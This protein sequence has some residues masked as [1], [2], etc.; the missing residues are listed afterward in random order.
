MFKTRWGWWVEKRHFTP[1]P[2]PTGRG[3]VPQAPCSTLKAQNR[4]LTT[5]NGKEREIGKGTPTQTE[6]VTVAAFAAA[7]SGKDIWQCAW[8]SRTKCAIYIQISAL[9]KRETKQIKKGGSHKAYAR[10]CSSCCCFKAAKRKLKGQ[11]AGQ[12]IIYFLLFKW[13]YTHTHTHVHYISVC[14][15]VWH[16]TAVLHFAAIFCSFCVLRFLFGSFKSEPR[17]HLELSDFR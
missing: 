8:Y 3:G 17:R 15:C 16:V 11:A 6:T 14:L 7:A 5:I 2:T 1:N 13:A 10:C 9:K 12:N 4:K